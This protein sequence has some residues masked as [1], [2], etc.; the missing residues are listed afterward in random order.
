MCATDHDPR[1]MTDEEVMHWMRQLIN[2][3][4]EEKGSAGGACSLEAINSPV[5]R[6]ILN[7][8]EEKALT[9]D[10]IS[11]RLS[12]TGSALRY[13]LNFLRSS[14]FIRIEGDN[15]DLTPGGVSVIRS[16]RRT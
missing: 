8:L 6:R 9:I 10:E 3:L 4:A 2:K 5:R 14:Y 15:V 16:N 12:V 1:D 11:Q 7:I 13:H